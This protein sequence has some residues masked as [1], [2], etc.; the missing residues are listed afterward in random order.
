MAKGRP[1]NHWQPQVAL[2]ILCLVYTFNYIDRQLV[3]L[4]A[5]PIKRDIGMTDTQL[6]LLSG[7]AFAAVYA[8]A[9]LPLA[10]YADRADRVRIVAFSCALWSIST[11]LCGAANSFV[12]M[13]IARVGVGIGE[14]G[15]VPPSYSIISDYYKARHRGI[16]IGIY[17]LGVPFGAAV[18]VAVG[19]WLTVQYGWRVTFFSIGGFGVF[20]S[21][22]LLIFVAEPKRG[23]LDHEAKLNEEP[24]AALQTMRALIGNRTFVSLMISCALCSFAFSGFASWVPAMLMRSKGM[25]M[26]EVA[27]YYS[28]VVGG[29][30]AFGALSGGYL[31]SRFS[32]NP[33]ISVMIPALLMVIAIPCLV[34]GSLLDSWTIGLFFLAIPLIPNMMFYT[35][36]MAII[37]NSVGAH[38]RALAAAVPTL[39]TNLIGT[40]LAPPFVGMVS[41]WATPRYG[42]KGIEIAI[43]SLSPFFLVAGL[44]I[45][46]VVYCIRRDAVQA[47]P[48]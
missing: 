47:E 6:G 33:V 8:L 3:S 19:G 44:S 45:L 20:L 4:L 21:L 48:A 29:S 39:I 30:I 22:C 9:G 7:F 43:I 31:N 18:G 12:H 2:F 40:G 17:S 10:W 13:A 38:Q 36:A 25:L 1:I 28:L 41:D 5:E 23:A 24:H 42:T 27:S 16:A 34:T 14:A 32:R 15:G 46:F 35:P 37:Q 26:G 11:G